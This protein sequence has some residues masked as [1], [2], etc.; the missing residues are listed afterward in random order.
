[1]GLP[2]IGFSVH[3]TWS[4]AD[5]HRI[6]GD[7]TV[8]A[9]V[10]LTIEPGAVVKFNSGRRL[11]ID[12]AISAAGTPANKII[13]TSYRDDSAGGDS[14]GDG[15]SRGQPADWADIYLGDS[16]TETLSQIQYVDVRYAGSRN[17]GSIYAYQNDITISDSTVMHHR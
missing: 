12:G 15:P 4:A 5:V 1:M 9:G 10:T 13:F 2:V 16:L 6:T 8:S 14:N 7:V 11:R 17:T 3:T